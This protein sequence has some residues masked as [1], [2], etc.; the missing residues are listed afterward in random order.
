MPL[1]VNG[2]DH[3]DG[4]ERQLVAVDTG[5]FSMLGPDL[6]LSLLAGEDCLIAEVDVLAFVESLDDRGKDFI[7]HVLLPLQL[8]GS[9]PHVGLQ[10]AVMDRI[11]SVDGDELAVGDEL[12]GELA[13]EELGAG[14]EIVLHLSIQG[15]GRHKPVDMFSGQHTT[16]VLGL[17]GLLLFFV[18]AVEDGQDIS[19]GSTEQ[20]GNVR[21]IVPDE[22]GVAM[23]VVAAVA[24]VVDD[25]GEVRLEHGGTALIFLVHSKIISNTS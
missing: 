11:F 24:E 8:A 20:L 12:V 22:V 5:R 16:A 17:L 13:V 9:E 10:D 3:G 18:G 1:T 23:G 7:L 19:E 2:S 14:S 4:S 25:L 21:R 15:L 6:G